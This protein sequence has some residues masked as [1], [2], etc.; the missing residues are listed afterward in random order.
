MS[1]NRSFDDCYFYFYST[2]TKGNACP[3]RHCEAALGTEAVCSLWREGNCSRKN[4]K[5]RHMESRINRHFIPCYWENQPGGCRKPHCV[6][7]HMKTKNKIS[8]LP[9]ETPVNLIL[10]VFAQPEN[11]TTA[12][13]MNELQVPD[14][15]KSKDSELLSNNSALSPVIEP[16][17]VSIDE[18]SDN[19]S[20]SPMK[21]AAD[22]QGSA[23]SGK[24]TLQKRPIS[25]VK[26]SQDID[27]GIKTLEQIRLEKV[28]RESAHIYTTENQ[29]VSAASNVTTQIEDLSAAEDLRNHLKR[30]HSQISQ[31]AQD[32]TVDSTDENFVPNGK[33]IDT[34]IKNKKPVIKRKILRRPL[35]SG[36]GDQNIFDNV[37]VSDVDSCKEAVPENSPAM[38]TNDNDITT[39]E[40]CE[41]E[42]SV[43]S[44]SDNFMSEKDNIER[45]EPKVE[46]QSPQ[47]IAKL[48]FADEITVGEIA[49]PESSVK[50]ETTKC[51][52]TEK[53]QKSEIC[54]KQPE[55]TKKK[56][57]NSGVQNTDDFD[58]L[59]LDND[60]GDLILYPEED[61]ME[62]GDDEL[63]Q[64]LEEIINS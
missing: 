13:N 62:K 63:L 48:N 17:V 5:F 64:E 3:F 24:V 25:K 7:L 54:V 21:P 53:L 15:V 8:N 47:H 6:F 9:V 40:V 18:E 55:Q 28:H 33:N 29:A 31:P 32:G 56:R 51:A 52:K 36:V 22:S 60:E 50:S 12:L 20:A 43:S 34:Q 30:K 19:E 61:N 58:A 37:S 23:V 42:A 27:L 11:D 38:S 16:V 14:L 45:L 10:P 1:G 46:G 49:K 57:Y 2:C 39:Q 35:F 59:L 44:S 4:C 26:S 41:K